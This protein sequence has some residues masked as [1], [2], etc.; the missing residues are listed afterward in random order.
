MNDY[1][2]GGQGTGTP[3]VKEEPPF[4]PAEKQPI[5][6]TVETDFGPLKIPNKMAK[7]KSFIK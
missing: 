3:P 6:K 5:E 7:S 1:G 2:S 4:I